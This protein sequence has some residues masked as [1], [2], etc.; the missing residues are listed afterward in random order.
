M[1][2]SRLPVL[3]HDDLDP[4]GLRVWDGVTGSRGAAMISAE[5]GLI[6]PFN[7]FLHAPDVGRRLSALG[8]AVRFETSLDRR[9]SE[10][11]IITVG[12]HWKAEFEW[13]AH[14]P[15]AREHGVPEAVIEAI[16]RGDEPPLEAADELAAYAVARQ[17]MAAG[18]VSP[19]TYQ[20]AQRLFGDA[21]M[22]ELISLCGYYT[23]IS[24]LL[25]GCGVPLPPGATPAW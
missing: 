16:R 6:G 11:V 8:Q 21:G 18:Q 9:V 19:D 5:G 3:R 20:T 14:V 23:L 10:L 4:D 13:W 24:F 25:N 1:T 17:L 2:A 15:A 7:A 12:A 22:V